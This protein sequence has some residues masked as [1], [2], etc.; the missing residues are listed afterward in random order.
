MH[1]YVSRP[2]LWTCF[3]KRNI[4]MDTN[5]F[6]SEFNRKRLRLYEMRC[7]PQGDDRKSSHHLPPL[8]KASD[9]KSFEFA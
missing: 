4:T 2:A 5:G 7:M 9:S 1:G 3:G 8:D 6:L